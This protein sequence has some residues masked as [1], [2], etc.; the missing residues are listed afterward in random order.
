MN[1]ITG[2]SQAGEH[3]H[4]Q[5]SRS[6]LGPASA[7]ASSTCPNLNRPEQSA[8]M[9]EHGHQTTSTFAGY[10]GVTVANS[11]LFN[12]LGLN[13]TNNQLVLS[14]QQQSLLRAAR[15]YELDRS[16]EVTSN[17]RLAYERL[18][19]A[20]AAAA[21][22]ANATARGSLD[23][24]LARQS[25]VQ[26]SSKDLLKFSINTILGRASS[27]NSTQSSIE[28]ADNQSKSSSSREN[29]A[30]TPKQSDFNDELWMS[31]ATCD[32]SE[33]SSSDTNSLVD[34]GA[35]CSSTH[36]LSDSI[37][38]TL[39]TQPTPGSVNKLFPIDN[40]ANPLANYLPRPV[41]H[42]ISNHEQHSQVGSNKQPLSS[43]LTTGPPTFPWT[44][45][46]RGKPRRGMMR[47][48][49][50]SDNQ[51][52]GLEK[53]F[54]LQKYISKPDRKKLAEKL[55][56]RDSQVK[57]WFQNRRMKWRNSKERELLSA[58]GSREQTLPTRNNPNP[59]LSDVGETIKRLTSDVNLENGATIANK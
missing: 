37:K 52:V 22:A 46:S 59:D 33:S 35:S 50:F 8:A 32:Q 15:Q 57:I 26:S 45:A 56:L 44:V 13:F 34:T 58:G 43:F 36:V 39:S 23:G 1:L 11:N 25:G 4:L 40:I 28:L 6:H 55:G 5:E 21:A 9:L 54:Q 30:G 47:R 2:H 48:A 24:E 12:A 29:Q 14:L 20:A 10:P 49:V 41:A 7:A 27:P 38:G 53:R 18:Y 16:N 19:T 42:H 17:Q 51:R 31:T 3:G